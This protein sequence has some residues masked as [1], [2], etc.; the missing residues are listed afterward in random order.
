MSFSWLIDA[1]VEF[2]VAFRGVF[3]HDTWALVVPPLSQPFDAVYVPRDFKALVIGLTFGKV[4][5]LDPST[6]TW[7]E[8][9]PTEYVTKLSRVGVYHRCGDW[10]EWHWDPIV[11]SI[12]VD[13]RFVYPQLGFVSTSKPYE[14]RI[15]NPTDLTIFIDVT[16]WMIRLPSDV[17]CPL[18][19]DSKGKCD[20]E[21]LFWRY[22]E[23]RVMYYM[24][25]GK[26]FWE[27]LRTPQDVDKFVSYFRKKIG[28]E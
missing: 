9:T 20:V 24:A 25:M 8:P 5:V 7:R 10:M 28:V 18:W 2:A 23:S 4:L 16:F 13:G 26:M 12:G 14:L 19:G 17:E 22:M 21:E 15:A 11:D 3:L 27:G 6:N 1:V